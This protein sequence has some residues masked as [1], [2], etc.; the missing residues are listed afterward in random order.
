M[1]DIPQGIIVEIEEI[2]DQLTS[3]GLIDP[4]DGSGRKFVFQQTGEIKTLDVNNNLSSTDVLDI[5][6]ELVDLFPVIPYDER[7]L[8]GVILHQV[9]IM[10]FFIILQVYQ[11]HQILQPFTFPEA[12][13]LDHHGVLV[14]VTFTDS[15]LSSYFGDGDTYSQR[16]IL[17]LE[18]PVAESFPII[19]SNHNSGSMSFDTN[20]YLISVLVMLVMQMIQEMAMD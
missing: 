14:E 20:G 6:D 16:E 1:P 5:S 2:T 11:F 8:L 13:N 4:N 17:R 7:G 9:L 12:T 15:N 3:Y 19:G 18:Q 10:E